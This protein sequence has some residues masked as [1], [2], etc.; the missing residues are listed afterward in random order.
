S[1]PW[2]NLFLALVF[3]AF[4]ASLLGA[5]EITLPSGVLTSVTNASYRGGITGA[6]IM[7][8]AFALASFA[9]TGPFVG[10]PLAGS[11]Q[12]GLYLPIVGMLVFSTGLASP[13]F[14]LALFPAY[15]SRLPRS[16]G[17]GGRG[18]GAGGFLLLAGG[19]QR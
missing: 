3:V 1:N 4:G 18:Q 6:L 11:T 17:G 9:C 5:F 16:G 15:V 2:V 13:F 8:L 14:F 19:A 7:G 12:G 10:T